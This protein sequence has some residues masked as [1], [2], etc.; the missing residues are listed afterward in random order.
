M[1]LTDVPSGSVSPVVVR[2]RQDSFRFERLPGEEE[3]NATLWEIMLEWKDFHLFM[4]SSVGLIALN[5]FVAAYFSL[6]AASGD[7]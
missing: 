1:V 2:E 4:V 5:G 3:D 7:N 6:H